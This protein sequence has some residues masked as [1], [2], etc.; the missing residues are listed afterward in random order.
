MSSPSLTALVVTCKGGPLLARCLHGLLPQ[1]GP[2]DQ[3]LVVVSAAPGASS[4]E[5]CPTEGVQW[6]E[7]GENLGFA[8]AANAGLAAAR[9]E[10][11]LLLNDD[12]RPLPGFVDALR[13][14]ARAPGLYQPRILL[15]DGGGRLDNAGHGLYPD[16]FNWARGREDLDGQDYDAPGSVGACSGAAMLLTRELLEAVGPFDEDLEAFGEDVDLSLRARRRGFPLRYVPEARIEHALGATY[17]RYGARKV[18]LVERNRVRAAV[19]SLPLS[20]LLTMPAWTGLRLAGLS[21]AAAGDRGWSGRVE[22]GARRAALK[23]IAAGLSHVPEAL[24]KRRADSASWALGEREMWAHLL[25]HR[26][27]LRD[28]LR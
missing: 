18:Y 26:V 6:L 11:L 12:T 4:R 25:T 21:L 13:E 2:E 9:G 3:A 24:A 19:R 20:A 15:L 27:R 28:V 7:L 22:P 10:A 8:R 23:G 16:G 5:G 14:A 17:G 1:L